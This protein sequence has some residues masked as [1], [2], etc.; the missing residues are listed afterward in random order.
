[1]KIS[2]MTVIFIVV[3]V[4]L[5]VGI[6][7]GYMRTQQAKQERELEYNLTQARQKLALIRTDD[8]EAQKD[9]ITREIQDYKNRIDS[10]LNSLPVPNDNIDATDT[11]LQTA[12]SLG[13]D[14]VNISSSGES[15][16]G[17]KDLAGTALPLNLT[18]EGSVQNIASFVVDLSRKFPTSTVK[19]V[20]IRNPE[21]QDAGSGGGQEIEPANAD[22]TITIFNYKGE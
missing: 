15:G 19:M 6:T 16:T 13:V 4:F 3:G 7:M 18:V 11:V 1:M 12:R 2:K 21:P 9:T 10:A 22:I 17:T 14:I 20:Q 8:L 5:I